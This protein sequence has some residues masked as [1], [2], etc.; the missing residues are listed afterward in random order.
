MPTAR[1]L[2]A[3][4]ARSEVFTVPAGHTVQE[5]CRLMQH[6]RVGSLVVG[7]GRTIDGMFTER[8]VLNRVV[9]E[10]RDPAATHVHE[11]MSAEVM[12]IKPDR[13]LEE[14]EAIMKQQRIRHLP[15]VDETGL[16]GLLSIG[17]VLAWHAARDKQTVEYLTEYMYGRH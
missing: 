2:L 3:T 11:V 14:I 1:E 9:A 13:P 17:D 15:V 8:D 16:L 10:G 5:A 6:Y 7:D 12:F 4:K